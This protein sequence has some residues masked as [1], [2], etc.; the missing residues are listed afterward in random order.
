MKE[1]RVSSDFFDLDLLHDSHPRVIERQLFLVDKILGLE[2]QLAEMLISRN[3]LHSSSSIPAE[4]EVALMRASTT[5]KIGRAIT[6][7]LSKLS[8]FFRRK[9]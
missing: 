4:T 7:P 9:I 3:Q 6:R 2:A 8:H 1:N 5:W